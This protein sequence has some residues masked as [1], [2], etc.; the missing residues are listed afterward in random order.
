LG[1]RGI[2][3]VVWATGYHRNYNWLHLP[4]LDAAGEIRHVAGRTPVPGLCVVGM[5]WQTRRNSTFLD[6]VGHDAGLVAEHILT[7][8]LHATPARR[9]AS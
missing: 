4:V 8:I 7:D 2:R 6:G 9:S 5:A 3:T 1:R